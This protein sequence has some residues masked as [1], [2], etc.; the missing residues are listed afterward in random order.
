MEENEAPHSGKIHRCNHRHGYEKQEALCLTTAKPKAWV[1]PPGLSDELDRAL[2][3]Q[4]ETEPAAWPAL[5]INIDM[6][7]EKPL[8][9]KSLPS[10]PAVLQEQLKSNI[11]KVTARTERQLIYLYIFM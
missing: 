11:S 4:L 7:E 8:S 10:S 3:N 6:A 5:H 9:E 2:Q 1:M